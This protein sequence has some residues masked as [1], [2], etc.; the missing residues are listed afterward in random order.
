MSATKKR[1]ARRSLAASKAR[2]KLGQVVVLERATS[3]GIRAQ[4]ATNWPLLLSMRE[5]CRELQVCRV[6]LYK[7]LSKRRLKSVMLGRRRMI[8]T[9]SL[10]KL[11]GAD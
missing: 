10:M 7:L 4:A 6:T 9:A 5:A 11:A 1:V 2:P 8:S 3:E